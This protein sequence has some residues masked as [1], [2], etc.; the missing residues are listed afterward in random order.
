[1]EYYSTP[2]ISASNRFDVSAITD[3][4][5]VITERTFKFVRVRSTRANLVLSVM[6]SDLSVIAR[7]DES[8]TG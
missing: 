5:R 2:W 1:M 4:S 7:I 8:I 6:T 3:K